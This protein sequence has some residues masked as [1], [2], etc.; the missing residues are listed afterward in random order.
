MQ[1]P[2]QLSGDKGSLA[3][4]QLP[5]EWWQQKPSPCECPW[6]DGGTDGPTCTNAHRAAAVSSP[7]HMMAS[8]ETVAQPT[9]L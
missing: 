9:K 2:A 7:T 3:H 1:Q 4:M 5:M 8:G 6:N